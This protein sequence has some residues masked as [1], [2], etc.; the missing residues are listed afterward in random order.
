MSKR[1]LGKELKEIRKTRTNENVSKER[2]YKKEP[3]SG[4]VK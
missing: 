2:N 1:K 3:N 4:V